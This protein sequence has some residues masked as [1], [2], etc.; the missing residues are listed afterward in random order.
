MAKF[1]WGN[2]AFVVPAVFVGMF[3]G[4]II[5]GTV[6]ISIGSDGAVTDDTFPSPKQLQPLV[7]ASAFFWIVW[8][9]LL[10]SQVGTK[11]SN[12]PDEYKDQAK[13]I[14]DRGV[15]NTMEQM[16][17]F[18]V[19]VWLNAL[20][21]NPHTAA[22]LA[23]IF[24][25]CRFVYP[26]FY[27]IYG[28]M[29]CLVELAQWPCYSVNFYLLM[30]LLFKMLKGSDLH[31][32]VSAVSPALIY[33]VTLLGGICTLLCF[34]LVPTPTVAMIQKGVKWNKEYKADDVKAPLLP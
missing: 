9:S 19:L 2:D 15:I 33:G 11:M 18:F 28:E 10:G 23:W 32:V 13:L 21:V 16:I 34:M 22:G 8:Y 5:T 4:A 24:L 17:P 3:L 27:G 6:L 7:V 31:G 1:P 20:F 26:M 25:L 14:A 30:A 12:E 29:N